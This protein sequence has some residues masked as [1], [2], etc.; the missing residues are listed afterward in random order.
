[1]RT[2]SCDGGSG[3][4]YELERLHT[5][6][7]KYRDYRSLCRKDL[8]L[9]HIDFPA[10]MVSLRETQVK[11]KQPASYRRG[12]IILIRSVK[13]RFCWYA[14]CDSLAANYSGQGFIS[15]KPQSVKSASRKI[16]I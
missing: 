15:Q 16:R 6:Y 7:K 9:H 4:E 11:A 3:A 8:G 14:A 5:V 10:H 2:L 13:L 1:V 12:P